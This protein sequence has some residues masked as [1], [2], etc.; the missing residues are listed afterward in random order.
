M[1]TQ[2]NESAGDPLRTFD[3]SRAESPTAAIVTAIS[4]QVDADPTT[5]EPLQSVI[6]TD[7][8]NA[9]FQQT[10]SAPSQARGLQFEYLGYSVVLNDQTG[11]LYE[12]S[13]SSTA[14]SP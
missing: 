2:H 6:D 9:L 12:Q 13:R 8:L 1:T 14:E 11:Y 4:E 5:V 10:P 7:A 3:L